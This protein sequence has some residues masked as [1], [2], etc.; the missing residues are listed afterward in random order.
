[1]LRSKQMIYFL[2]M[3]FATPMIPLN[4]GNIAQHA[5]ELRAKLIDPR[6]ENAGAFKKWRLRS[7]ME[8]GMRYKNLITASSRITGQNQDGGEINRANALRNGDMLAELKAQNTILKQQA[9]RSYVATNFELSAPARA[10]KILFGKFA[11]NLPR[12]PIHVEYRNAATEAGV[13]GTRY[14]VKRIA[15]P[16]PI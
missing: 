11:A 12:T 14:Q 4:N 7:E 5:A 16:R 2:L 13:H 10:K 3:I 15:G 8:K 9:R 6:Y 1:M